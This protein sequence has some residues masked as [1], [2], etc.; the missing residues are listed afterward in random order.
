MAIPKVL[1]NIF[2]QKTAQERDFRNNDIFAINTS[3]DSQQTLVIFRDASGTDLEIEDRKYFS[4]SKTSS[5]IGFFPLLS[6]TSGLEF[7]AT[8]EDKPSIIGTGNIIP[9]PGDEYVCAK[10]DP[11]FASQPG[12]VEQVCWSSRKGVMVQSS[13]SSGRLSRSREA[14]A[15]TY[16]CVHIHFKNRIRFCSNC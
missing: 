15:Y 12:Q 6:P 7:G 9:M 4:W 13:K 3:M 10:S 2:E 1:L 5:D 16:A 11:G 8:Q 14:P